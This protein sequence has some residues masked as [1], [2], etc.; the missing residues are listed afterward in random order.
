M[1][2]DPLTIILGSKT[3]VKL[4]RRLIFLERSVTGREA[5]RLAGVSQIAQRS[6]DEFVLVGVLECTVTSGAYHYRVNERNYL[7]P[8]LRSLF[9]AEEKRQSMISDSLRHVL[10]RHPGVLSAVVF[11]SAARGEETAES[12]LDLLVVVEERKS[13]E[14]VQEALRELASTFLS[15]HGV[16]LS[17]V[18]L[19]TSE[20]RQQ[21]GD[22]D[23][24]A[25]HAFSQSRNVYGP[26]VEELIHG[27]AI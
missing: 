25:A 23:S 12:D 7:V 4:L 6:L 26:S 13:K 19:T 9:E 21:M 3:K 24:F 20:V 16:T 15:E 10:H 2:R 27:A 17:P 11:G 1:L 14:S 8:F 22:R 5:T 18:L